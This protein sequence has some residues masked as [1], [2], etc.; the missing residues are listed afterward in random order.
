[1]C[2]GLPGD[3][4]SRFI[5]H[6]TFAE[7]GGD[8][9]CFDR[10]D[11][12]AYLSRRSLLIGVDRPEI[13]LFQV[14]IAGKIGE[15]SLTGYQPAFIGRNLCQRSMERGQRLVN[16]RFITFGIFLVNRGVIRIV[17]HQRVTNIIDVD[18]RIFCRHP[19]MGI[20]FT[21]VRPFADAHWFHPVRHR[22]VRY[23]RQILIEAGKP[24][25]QIQTV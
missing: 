20:R 12:F 25:F 21:V 14:V 11:H 6:G 2:A 16:L 24:Q 10:I 3:L 8:L 17:F 19:G 5:R 7:H 18:H 13:Q 1:M 15:R 9:M 22:H 4:A 23:A